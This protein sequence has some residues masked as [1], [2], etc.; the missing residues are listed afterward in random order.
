[1]I[2]LHAGHRIGVHVSDA[3]AHMIFSALAL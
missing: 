3:T 1:M 2:G